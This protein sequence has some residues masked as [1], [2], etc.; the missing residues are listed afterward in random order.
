MVLTEWEWDEIEANLS[1]L[2]TD[3]LLIHSGNYRPD[4]LSLTA[5]ISTLIHTARLLNMQ[6]QDMTD[7]FK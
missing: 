7:D 6:L 4:K 2:Y 1:Y 5:S 3:L